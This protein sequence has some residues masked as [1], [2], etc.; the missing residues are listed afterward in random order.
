MSKLHRTNVFVVTRMHLLHP[1]SFI[2]GVYK[3]YQDAVDIKDSYEQ[4][5]KDDG[6]DPNFYCE[7]NI[8]TF[9]ETI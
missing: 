9:Y 6:I 7:V 2:V 4:Q 8:A 5:M 3:V 1:S